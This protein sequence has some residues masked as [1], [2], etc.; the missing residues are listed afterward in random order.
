MSKNWSIDSW[1]GLPIKHQPIYKDSQKLEDVENLN[2]SETHISSK[3][4]NLA[5]SK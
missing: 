2:P 5:E 4:S 3:K 1:R